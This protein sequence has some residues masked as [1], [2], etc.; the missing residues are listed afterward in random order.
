MWF[1]N[2]RAKVKRD[3]KESR[4]GSSHSASF[5]SGQSS[6]GS[7]TSVSPPHVQQPNFPL[8]LYKPSLA[9][10]SKYRPLLIKP[11]DGNPSARPFYPTPYS[12]SNM[13]HDARPLNDPQDATGSA[14]KFCE[15][16]EGHGGDMKRD[17]G[18]FPSGLDTLSGDDSDDTLDEIKKLE[19]EDNDN[20]PVSSNLSGHDGRE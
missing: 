13:P 9:N 3:A 5:G 8:S 18:L 20:I 7:A 11:E 4:G 14:H 17:E 6:T 19:A 2:R 16:T 1:K 10:T 12:L 15:I